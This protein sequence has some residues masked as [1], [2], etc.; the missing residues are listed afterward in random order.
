MAVA[1]VWQGPDLTGY[2]R[3]GE[4][5]GLGV[6]NGWQYVASA[7]SLAAA[8]NDYGSPYPPYPLN[9]PQDVP[10]LPLGA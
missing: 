4:T 10:P 1:F 5:V 8:R 3:G 9:P 7:A 6:Q 2:F